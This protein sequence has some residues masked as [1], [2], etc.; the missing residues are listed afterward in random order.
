MYEV[1]VRTMRASLGQETL[2]VELDEIVVFRM[3]HHDAVVPGN[4]VHRQLNPAHVQPHTYAS[5]MR[6]HHVSREYLEARKALLDHVAYLVEHAQWKRAYQA[7]MEG[8]VDERVALPSC[9]ALL[10]CPRDV[11]ARLDEAKIQVSRRCAMSHAASV[12][13][14]SERALTGI[15]VGEVVDVEVCMR[16]DSAGHHDLAGRVDRAARLG[17]LIFRADEHDLLA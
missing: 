3:N 13:F 8:I 9:G 1:K 6:G 7:D 2:V 4:F 12:V 10:D 5:R 16:L 17:C 15:G 14:R 11:H